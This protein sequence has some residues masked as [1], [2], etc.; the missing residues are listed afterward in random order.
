[1]N[2]TYYECVFKFEGDKY[3]TEA[4]RLDKFEFGFW[5]NQWWE[6]TVG[7][8]CTYWIPPGK[9]QHIEKK[10]RKARK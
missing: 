5:V 6:Y 9:I 1:M 3:T 10:T 2:E 4:D 7:S 8:D